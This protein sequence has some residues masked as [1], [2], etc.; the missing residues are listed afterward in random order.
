[1]PLTWVHDAPKTGPVWLRLTKRGNYYIYSS[2][3][4]GKSFQVYGE[5]PWGNGAPKWIGLAAMNGGK[6]ESP[7][8]D[9]SFDFRSPTP[10]TTP[11]AHRANR[12]RLVRTGKG[13]RKQALG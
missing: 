2:S 10:P 8:V 7:E 6:V 13:S 9:A 4:D 12:I 5:L 1:M 11:K 3:T